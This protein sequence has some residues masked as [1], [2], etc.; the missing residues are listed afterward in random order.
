MDIAQL[1]LF[2][3]SETLLVDDERGRIAYMP[4]FIDADTAR[5]DQSRAPI[6]R[7]RVEDADVA[8]SGIY[9]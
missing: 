2:G 9:R 6:E 5:A 1:T 8:S 4:A 3:A 7:P